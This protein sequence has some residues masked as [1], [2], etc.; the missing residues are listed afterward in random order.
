MQNVGEI[1]RRISLNG[2]KFREYVNGEQVTTHEGTLNVVILNAA[3]ISRSYY[4]GDYDASNPTRPK[5][6]SAD[7]SE[8]APEV[9]QE[10]RQANRCMDCPQNIKGSGAGM[11]RACRFAQRVA[12]VLEGDFTKVYQLQL[13]ATS[14]FGKAKDGKMPMQAYAQYLSSHNTPAISVVTECAFDQGS[15]VPK[16]FF[17]AVRPLREEEV[18]LAVSLAESKETKEAITMSTS[19]PSRGSIF[20]EVDGFVYDSANA[21]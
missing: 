18:S 15:P 2:G 21:N 4:A 8:P 20:A 11:S 19:I 5:C 16:L 13:P 7:T 6:W 1:R 17:K 12:V 9:K 10:D 14:L 3:K